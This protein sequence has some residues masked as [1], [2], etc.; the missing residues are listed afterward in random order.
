MNCGLR[1]SLGWLIGTG[2]LVA[3]LPVSAGAQQACAPTTAVL[4]RFR[5]EHG[6]IP[7]IAMLD[8]RGNRLVVLVN[9]ATRSW[10]MFALPSA[11]DALA[12]LIAAGHE[13]GPGNLPPGRQS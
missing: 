12:C 6:E 7:A 4:E 13:F 10:S 8:Q 11:N 1:T 3:L 2:I 5:T 9:P